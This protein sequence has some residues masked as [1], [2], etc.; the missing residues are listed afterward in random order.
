M[1]I[2]VRCR[3]YLAGSLC[4]MFGGSGAPLRLSLNLNLLYSGLANPTAGGMEIRTC[5]NANL[6]I[7]P[8]PPA[9]DVDKSSMGSWCEVNESSV[10]IIRS[11]S[12]HFVVLSRDV[13]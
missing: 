3:N 10:I 12:N 11:C 5:P 4:V 8:N 13:G 7:V 9:P 6:W 2:R 1:S